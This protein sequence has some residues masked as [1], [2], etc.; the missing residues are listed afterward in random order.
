MFTPKDFH[1]PKR[2]DCFSVVG[3]L[4]SSGKSCACKINEVRESFSFLLV[5]DYYHQQV[6]LF[7]QPES[8][9][10]QPRNSPPEIVL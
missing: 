7:L 6:Q 4:L 1:I 10:M 3:K 5:E 2:M 8:P 9:Q